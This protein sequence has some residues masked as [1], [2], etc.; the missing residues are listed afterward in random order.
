[1]HEVHRSTPSKVDITPPVSMSSDDFSG[2]EPLSPTGSSR[3]D[4]T[5]NE[6]DAV[7][8]FL[9]SSALTGNQDDFGPPEAR[10]LVSEGLLIRVEA[11][12]QV[13]ITGQGDST[14]LTTEYSLTLFHE[15]LGA[16]VDKLKAALASFSKGDY[17]AFH[18]YIKFHIYYD[19]SLSLNSPSRSPSFSAIGT[20]S[21]LLSAVKEYDF[22]KCF[23]VTKQHDH[24]DYF[25]SGCWA[26]IAV[27]KL[28]SI[29]ALRKYRARCVM[30]FSQMAVKSGDYGSC[31]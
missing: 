7:D 29:E 18:N 21:E 20:L 14:L 15:S 4:I 23:H 31:W 12:E 8:D 30:A 28:D 27:L 6:S 5:Y 16:A 13:G 10:E 19:L 9:L 3:G 17:P 1:M 22:S 26:S 25:L 11:W 2:S 24:I